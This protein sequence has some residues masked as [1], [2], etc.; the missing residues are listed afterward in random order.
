M[1]I[2]RDQYFAQ[3]RWFADRHGKVCRGQRSRYGFFQFGVGL[4]LNADLEHPN[5]A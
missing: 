3:Q 5:I 1:E 2:N 4:T